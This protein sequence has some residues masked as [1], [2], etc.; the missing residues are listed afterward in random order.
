M[1]KAEVYRAA[2]RRLR[3]IADQIETRCEPRTPRQKAALTSAVYGL[4]R[5][6]Q[7]LSQKHRKKIE[8]KLISN[9]TKWP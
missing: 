7:N 6:A 2:A 3:K 4:S 1:L 9:K 5:Y 8:G